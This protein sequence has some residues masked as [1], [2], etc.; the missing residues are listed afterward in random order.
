MIFLHYTFRLLTS[1]RWLQTC[2][3]R[4]SPLGTLNTK[5]WEGINNNNPWSFAVLFRNPDLVELTNELAFSDYRWQVVQI[6]G[7]STQQSFLFFHISQWTFPV[8]ITVHAFFKKNHIARVKKAIESFHL[9]A[10]KRYWPAHVCQIM[11]LISNQ[12]SWLISIYLIADICVKKWQLKIYVVDKFAFST[13]I[14]NNTDYLSNKK[15]PK[16][17]ITLW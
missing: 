15:K 2:G 10:L 4:G 9:F 7:K 6:T 14:Y 1:I 3:K 16:P 17:C 11:E 8:Y 12:S 5:E 13:L